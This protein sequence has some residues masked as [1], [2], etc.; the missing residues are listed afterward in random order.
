MK[1]ANAFYKQTMIVFNEVT[2]QV[3]QRDIFPTD[4]NT[5]PPPPEVAISCGL[6]WKNTGIFLPMSTFHVQPFMY[7]VASKRVIRVSYF[8]EYKNI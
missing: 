8:Q 5:I 2:D 4:I 1:L 3:S 6:I 7:K